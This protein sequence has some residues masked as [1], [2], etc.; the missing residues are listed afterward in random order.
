MHRPA[1][2]PGRLSGDSFVRY[3]TQDAADPLR[4]ARI[5]RG[6]IMKHPSPKQFAVAGLLAV[7]GV[8]QADTVTFDS[9]ANA[10]VFQYTTDTYTE[11][12][13]SFAATLQTGG[14]SLYSWGTASGLDA[15][16]TG[17]TLSQAYDGYGVRCASRRCPRRGRRA[18]F[19]RPG[20][21]LQPGHGGD[22]PVQL[23]RRARHAQQRPGACGS[24]RAADTSVPSTYT[25]DHVRCAA[26][27]AT[28]TTSSSITWWWP[29]ARP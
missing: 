12:G 21:P 28:R 26:G 20:R 9:L 4:P 2:R 11:Q 16:P 25:G 14:D 7:A 24:A 13:Y 19:V 15:D 6:N 29:A 18:H 8:A 5:P 23:H 27:C 1:L 3:V 10:D 17:A 22:D